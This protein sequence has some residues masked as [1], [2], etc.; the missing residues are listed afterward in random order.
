[1]VEVETLELINEN[2]RKDFVIVCI[3][4]CVD[5][6]QKQISGYIFGQSGLKLHY[7]EINWEGMVA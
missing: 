5:Y 1:M 7:M 6:K 3:N 4:S 2:T